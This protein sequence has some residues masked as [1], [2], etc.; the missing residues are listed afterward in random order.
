MSSITSEANGRRT[1]QFTLGDGKRRSLRLGKLSQREV[2]S[3]Q[4]HVDDLVACLGLGQS[5]R[6]ETVAWINRLSESMH[7]KL[8]AVGLVKPRA[9]ADQTQIGPF[10]ERYIASREDFK[11]QTKINCLRALKALVEHF[12]P[13]RSMASITQGDAEAFRQSL[14]KQGLAENT[15]RRTCGRA[16]QFYNAAI[17]QE[18]LTRS[19]FVEL[20][21]CVGANPLRRRYVTRAQAQRVL[22]ECPD[23]EWRLIFA[24]SRFGGLRC[25][26]QKAKMLTV[27]YSNIGPL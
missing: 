15:V 10:V 12:G 25:W 18:L 19:P 13:Q 8:A 9:A 21:R 23:N 16:H 26:V 11:P 17:R 4:R 20:K 1:I 22:D 24:L 14:L 27:R 7:A 3:V 2:E 6:Q 5:P